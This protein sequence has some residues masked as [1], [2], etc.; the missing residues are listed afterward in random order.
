MATYAGDPVRLQFNLYSPYDPYDAA[1][2]DD[3][4]DF[5]ATLVRNGA[6]TTIV[7]TL[8]RLSVGVYLAEFTIP[9]TW[10]RGDDLSL[11]VLATVN[12]LTMPGTVW[13]ETLSAGTIQPTPQN[14]AGTGPEGN[15]DHLGGAQV[16]AKR[17]TITARAGHNVTVQ[18]NLRRFGANVDLGQYGFNDSETGGESEPAPHVVALITEMKG[19]DGITVYT[20]VLQSETG[21]ISFELPEAVSDK[22]GIWLIEFAV[23]DSTESRFFIDDAYLYVERSYAAGKEPVGPPTVQEVRLFLR[24]YAQENELIDV[25]DFDVSEIAFAAD[26]CVAEW[27]EMPPSDGP[28]YSTGNFP[29]RRNWLV[30]ISAYLFGIAA[31]HYTRN[32]L[33]YSAGGVSID[34]K[35][36]HMLYLQKQQLARSEWRQFAAEK[37][38]LASVDGGWCIVPGVM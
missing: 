11:R 24:D 28:R 26:M 14:G 5:I 34:D 36:K 10:R 9:R 2:P 30:G 6:D 13:R 37:K 15:P 32:T 12:G 17:R 23:I 18:L 29:Y 4:T 1:D 21:L 7:V 35:A 33:A 25:V 22:A 27:N 3:N 16:K 8:T 31:E 38:T 19:C 20:D